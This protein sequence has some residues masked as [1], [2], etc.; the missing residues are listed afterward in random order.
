MDEP[1]KLNPILDEIVK[2]NSIITDEEEHKDPT[3]SFFK[4]SLSGSPIPQSDVLYYSY[5]LIDEK[6]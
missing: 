3:H 5:S 1:E 4:S 6:E 2:A